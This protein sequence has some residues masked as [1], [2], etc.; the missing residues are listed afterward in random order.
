M[1]PKPSET[2]RRQR[3]LFGRLVEEREKQPPVISEAVIRNNAM[4][5]PHSIWCLENFD[6]H[7]DRLWPI[8]SDM[9][10]DDIRSSII[11]MGGGREKVKR[12]CWQ[13]LYRDAVRWG[14]IG[15]GEFDG[16]DPALWE[17][18]RERKRE[19]FD[20]LIRMPKHC[21][22]KTHKSALRA[23]LRKGVKDGFDEKLEGAEEL[24]F[25]V[26]RDGLEITT[27]FDVH[28]STVDLVLDHGIRI[29]KE[30]EVMCFKSSTTAWIGLSRQTEW[31]VTGNQQELELMVFQAMELTQIFLDGYPWGLDKLE[32]PWKTE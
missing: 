5:R 7:F 6:R 15:V 19:A 31:N 23:A 20:R 14:G 21:K 2:S 8:I 27:S 24:Y 32:P 16:Y 22:S 3:E 25:C 4:C 28:R 13:C 30:P 9:D 17:N 29:V 18:N 11:G 1:E 12:D 10:S 26:C